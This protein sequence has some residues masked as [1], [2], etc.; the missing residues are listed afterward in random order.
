M[1]P[2]FGFSRAGRPDD[3]VVE[4]KS[5]EGKDIRSCGES[6]LTSA[7]PG[8]DP[9]LEKSQKKKAQVE[10]QKKNE[11]KNKQNVRK[12][13]EEKLGIPVTNLSREGKKRNK[14]Q[15]EHA[16]NLVKKSTISMG[17]FDELEDGEK[18]A[19]KRTKV[20]LY[21]FLLPQAQLIFFFSL[22]FSLILW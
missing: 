8:F 9:F 19:K 2:R 13:R 7:E 18:R 22:F 5:S 17:K 4:A 6:D 1:R 15:V 14:T 11:M 3:W 10:K 20:S 16:Y 21:V 12:I